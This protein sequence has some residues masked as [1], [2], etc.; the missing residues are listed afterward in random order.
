MRLSD[1]DLPEHMHL[2]E[3]VAASFRRRLPSSVQHDDLRAAGTLGLLYALRS[4]EHT[5]PEMFSAYAR[6]RIRGA[7]LDELRRQDHAPRRS[8]AAATPAPA[9]SANRTGPELPVPAVRPEIRVLG[10]DDAGPEDMILADDSR[11][12]LACVSAKWSAEAV[13]K[14]VALLPNREREV[15]QL[16][17]FN[18]VPS[19]EV[20]ARMG[21][22]EARVSQ[23]HSRATDRLRTMLAEHQVAA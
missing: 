18:E 5:C 8:R 11:S 19:K 20:A 16:R 13:Q 4:S 9:P 23:L 14:A 2:V 1:A 21:V 7:I 10:L 12:P 17:Y 22:S 3:K 6:T 15:I